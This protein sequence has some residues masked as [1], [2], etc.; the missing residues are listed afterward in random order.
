MNELDFLTMSEHNDGEHILC[1]SLALTSNIYIGLDSGCRYN[2]LGGAGWAAIADSLEL[3]T[4]LT[5]LNGC[6]QYSAIRDGG[7][8]EL[9]LS[10]SELG[11]WAARFLERSSSTLTKLDLRCGW[12]LSVSRGVKERKSVN[13]LAT[14]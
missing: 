11:L 10:N 6:D 2:W 13:P 14:W 8:V 4:S 12:N 1:V 9:N 7:L 5:S 3:L